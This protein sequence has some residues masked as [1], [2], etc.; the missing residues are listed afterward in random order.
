MRIVAE[1]SV[2]V[3]S[4]A[5]TV[6]PGYLA[7]AVDPKGAELTMDGVAWNRLVGQIEALGA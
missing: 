4:Y 3:G 1:S 7:I 5:Y 6:V 2:V